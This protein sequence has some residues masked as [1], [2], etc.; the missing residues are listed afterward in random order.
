MGGAVSLL[1]LLL[2]AY[3]PLIDKQLDPHAGLS[4][5]VGV[6]RLQ[7]E[8]GLGVRVA[9]PRF[10][11]D[12]LAVVLVGGVGW[13]PDLRALPMN[14]EDQD[15]GSWSLYGHARLMLE[16]STK[17]ALL[18]GRLYAKLGPSFLLLSSQ[19]ST[20]RVGFGGYGAVG[21]EVFAGD[22]YRSYPFSFYFEIGGVAHSAS[23][24]VENR[25]GAPQMTDTTVDRLIGTGL[26][27]AGG[28][29]I[30]LWR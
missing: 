2:S 4:L 17:I 6:Q 5:G 27:L 14:M 28:V 30:Y 10:L 26:A 18:S 15:F 20:S 22:Q 3:D 19:L 29:R 13:Y 8:F 11:S 25:T 23:A 21:I 7:D 12:R 16:A 24:D 1:A 9:T